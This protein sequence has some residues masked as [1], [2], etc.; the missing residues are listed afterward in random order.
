VS[1][2]VEAVDLGKRFGRRWALRH[3]SVRIP[4]GGVVGLVGVNGAGKTTLLHLAVGLLEPTE[5]AVA[6]VGGRPGGSTSLARVGFLAQDA[7]VYRS[8]TVAEHLV[9]GERLNPGWDRVLAKDRIARLGLD[10]SQR[11]GR[12]SGGQR[13]QLALTLSMAKQPEL[14]LLDEPVASLDPLARR[15]FLGDLMGLVAERGPTVVLSSH[16]LA[17][18][19]RVCDHLIVLAHGRVQLHG[20]V[21][22]LLSAHKLLTGARRDVTSL[23]GAQ[24]PIRVSHTER[25]TTVLIRTEQPVLDPHWAVTDVGLEELVLAY[26]ARPLDDDDREH[27]EGSGPHLTAVS[28]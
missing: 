16:S 23:P 12:L 1:A 15:E 22:E 18:V 9:L 27:D 3:C 13:A 11:G 25:Q 5:G 17:D 19:E 7:P 28:A 2:A 24:Q 26:L 20:R 6:T 10:P 14:L 8:L 4:A 21:D